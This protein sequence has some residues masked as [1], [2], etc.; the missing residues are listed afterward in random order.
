MTDYKPQTINTQH[1]CMK[2]AKEDIQ[3]HNDT[4]IKK[5]RVVDGK[6]QIYVT[7]VSRTAAEVLHAGGADLLVISWTQCQVIQPVCSGIA[8]II[9]QL[10]ISD[11]FHT[12]FP[13]TQITRV[14]CQKV[15]I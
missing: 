6:G 7:K 13:V 8:H 12:Q 3:R 1:N 11:I 10:G 2:P 15:Y 14:S 4:Y 9:Q 5:H